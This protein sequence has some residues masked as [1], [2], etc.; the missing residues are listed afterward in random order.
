MGW[1]LGMAGANQ[2]VLVGRQGKRLGAV[3]GYK[4]AGSGRP[5]PI[6]YQNS[7]RH[8]LCHFQSL[9]TA[10]LL[11]CPHSHGPTF[12]VRSGGVDQRAQ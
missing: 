6:L 5:A 3:T 11:P 10:P 8:D 12:Q 4:E 1:M 9:P 7:S 2:S